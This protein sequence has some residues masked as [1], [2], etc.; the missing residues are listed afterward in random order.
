MERLLGLKQDSKTVFLEDWGSNYKKRARM[1][2]LW[3]PSLQASFDGLFHE[4]G[5]IRQRL[6]ER[7]PSLI[8]GVVLKAGPGVAPPRTTGPLSRLPVHSL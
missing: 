1:S 6:L 7:F 8:A 4:P 2:A 3:S 5:R